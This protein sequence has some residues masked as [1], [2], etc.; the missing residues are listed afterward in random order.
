MSP[1]EARSPVAN[2]LTAWWTFWAAMLVGEV[3][4]YLALARGPLAAPAG[5][6]ESLVDLIGTI[7]QFLSVI[8]RWLIWPRTRRTMPG[9][10][11]FTLGIA[12]A[13]M[14]AVL[15]IFFG[16]PYRDLIFLLGILATAQFVPL[17]ARRFYQAD[18]TAIGK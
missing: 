12:L 18:G 8:T 3:V 11:I 6:R 7:P 5:T 2:R 4:L 9:F 15:G 1:S 17:D 14:T 16:G 10:V 13:E